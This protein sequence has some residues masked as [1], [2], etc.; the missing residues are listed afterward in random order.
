M[1]RIN[2]HTF[3]LD[4]N[5]YKLTYYRHDKP[6][7]YKIGILFSGNKSALLIEYINQNKLSLNLFKGQTT[8]QLSDLIL[9]HFSERNLKI[10][11][12]KKL[13]K[14]PESSKVDKAKKEKSSKLS[15]P[16][17]NSTA[18]EKIE[19]LLNSLDWKKFKDKNQKKLLIIG[20]SDSKSNLEISKDGLNHG[21]DYFSIP[22]GVLRESREKFYLNLINTNKKYFL[23]NG[24]PLKRN[25]KEVN[26]NYFKECISNKLLKK[27][28]YRY[29]GEFYTEEL[30]KLY[31]TK[32]ENSSLR[33]L[34][35][36][37]LYGVLEFDDEIFDYHLQIGRGGKK[38]AGSQI[39]E[40]VKKYIS[41]NKIPNNNVFYSLSPSTGY[42]EVL[43][44]EIGN[45]LWIN[46]EGNS[47]IVNLGH[48]A[49]CVLRF[50]KRL[51]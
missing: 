28:I 37:G 47:R 18:D 17:D 44:P 20:C 13:K 46:G 6:I 50:L 31:E 40:V 45:D 30:R 7:L 29:N 43:K 35:I 42:N 8:Q 33:I 5:K 34:I 9:N 21:K 39:Q 16:K 38:W 10:I 41:E 25:G 51:S 4:N 32:Y 23:K 22:L 15:K 36:S 26:S 2:E 14:Q 3:E 19:T 1:P 24:K 49:N 12:N 27:A 48:S 11:E